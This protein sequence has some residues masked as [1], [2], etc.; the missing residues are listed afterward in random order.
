MLNALKF[1][2]ENLTQNLI[3]LVILLAVGLLCWPLAPKP[4][5]NPTGI[6]LPTAP[7]NAPISTNQVQILEAMPPNAK[8]LGTINTKLY[9]SSLSIA[10][11]NR[12]MAAS[13]NYAKILAAQAGANGI[14]PVQIGTT[15]TV[16][17]LDGFVVQANAISY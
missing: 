2:K 12:D 14:V 15:G 9:F 13:F 3:G 8:I 7:L 1:S 11:E 5:P 17:P 16:N 6:L 10:E 4:N